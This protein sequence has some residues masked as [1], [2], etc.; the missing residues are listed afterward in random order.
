MCTA[1]G[2]RCV[3]G[4]PAAL[5]VLA[6]CLVVGGLTLLGATPGFAQEVQAQIGRGP[7]YVGE[8]ITLQVV[9][10]DFAEDPT[11]EIEE[12]EIRGGTLRFAG[13]S[14]SVSSSVSIVNGRMTRSSEVRFVFQYQVI[15]DR[16]GRLDVPAFRVRQGQTLRTTDPIRLAV[17]GVPTTGMVDLSVALPDGPIFVGQKVPVAV[18]LRIDREAERDLI[19]YAATVPL[20]DAPNLRFLDAPRNSPNV[21]E[22][23]TAEGTLR[24]P[25]DV[26]EETVGGRTVL[27]LRAERTMIALSPEPL[28]V[29]SPRVVISRGTRFRRDLFGGRQPTSSERLMAEGAPVDLEVIEVPRIG[30]PPTWSGAVGSGYTLEVATDRSVVQVGEPIVLSFL[31]RGDG[32][33]SSAGLPPFDAEGFLDP[34][35]FRLPEEPPAGLVDADGKRFEVSLRVLDASVREIPALEYAWFDARTRRF[36]TRRTRPIALSVGAAQ[37]IGAD[38]VTRN[39]GAGDAG[40]AGPFRDD[41]PT[42]PDRGSRA[43]K[44]DVLTASGAN[45]AIET[46]AERVLEGSAPVLGTGAEVP[47]LYALSLALLGF[48]AFDARRRQ[49]DPAD[50][51]RAG[52]LAAARHGVD[53]A[54]DAGA[55]G[56]VL[57]ELVAARP[58]AA[59]GDYDALL[60]ECDALRF[61]PGG[62][63]A[64]LPPALTDRARRFLDDLEAGEGAS[65]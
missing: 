64:S 34:A 8:P 21:L 7:H 54:A 32:D 15:A 4:P 65:T 11:P 59:S 50:V 20:F 10:V 19:E 27:V 41:A 14:P 35:Q 57:R 47:A 13:V 30:R 6:A 22:I 40:A 36:E 61:A 45:L 23:E 53:G 60:A 46:R 43:E 29:A 39:A 51:A 52:A 25:A 17:Q 58:E 18:E 55:L 5:G 1:F 48:A 12:P 49:R 16:T 26:R 63:S 2:A 9:A 56:R 24:L 42:A 62:E 3:A 37:I 28:R 33:L 31:L 38:D 44:R